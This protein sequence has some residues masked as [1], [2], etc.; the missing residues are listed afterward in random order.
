MGYPAPRRPAFPDP[1]PQQTVDERARGLL[2]IPNHGRRGSGANPNIGFVGYDGL[3]AGDRVLLV[4]TDHYDDAVVDGVRRAL[5]SAGAA[6]DRYRRAAPPDRP[7]RETDE[8]AAIVRREP[9]GEFDQPA[10]RPRRY[11]YGPEQWMLAHAERADYDAMLQGFAGPMPETDVRLEAFPWQTADGFAS[12]A[13]TYPP[14]LHRHIAEVAWRPIWEHPGAT[15]RLTDPEGTDLTYTLAPEYYERDHPVFDAEPVYGHLMGHSPPPILDVED[16]SGVVAGTTSHYNRPF[17]R[18]ELTVE[19]GRVTAVDGGGRYGEQWRDLL[20][21]TREVQYPSFPRPGLFHLWE[22]AIGTNPWVHRP[23]DALWRSGGGMEPERNRAGV[24]HLGFGTAWG[25]PAERWAGEEGHPY[26]HLHVH[27]LF[28]TF[29]VHAEGAVHTVVED[30]RLT[31]LDDPAVREHAADIG[32]PDDLLAERWIPAIPGV[33]AP[34][35]YA[36]YAAD[37][38]PFVERELAGG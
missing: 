14:A 36:D 19:A 10:T 26:G 34:G 32:D 4:A 6:V 22:V 15:V 30:G 5:E 13:T 9:F 29:E 33:N 17:P 25:S 12:A 1:V 21:E 23:R 2:G 20:A 31:A 37:P 38:A 35:A 27:L 11:D 24:I 7:L 16:A 28:P 18:I 8:V 3:G